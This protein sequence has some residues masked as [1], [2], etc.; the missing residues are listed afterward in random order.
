M[1]DAPTDREDGALVV[2][3]FLFDEQRLHPRTMMEARDNA[4]LAVL[5]RIGLACL[6]PTDEEIRAACLAFLRHVLS[7]DGGAK[8]DME[9]DWAA[10][11][12][13]FEV[14]TVMG[15]MRA[16]F[17]SFARAGA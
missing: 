4:K 12:P 10:P 3:A 8:A 17:A 13:S 11:E 9:K 5:A 1:S 14:R 15:A 2:E 6:H 16:A 7:E